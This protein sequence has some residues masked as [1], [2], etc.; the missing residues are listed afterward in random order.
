MTVD[1]PGDRD[2]AEWYWRKA[3]ERRPGLLTG[4]SQRLVQLL[5]NYGAL[6]DR[7]GWYQPDPDNPLTWENVTG[8]HAT[9]GARRLAKVRV[10]GSNPVARST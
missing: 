3:G 9:S 5:S 10:A 1:S 7:T 4:S 6:Q 8:R 2:P